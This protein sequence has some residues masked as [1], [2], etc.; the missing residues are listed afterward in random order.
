MSEPVFMQMML[1]SSTRIALIYAYRIRSFLVL[2]TTVSITSPPHLIIRGT[3]QWEFKSNSTASQLPVD[4]RVGIESVVHTTTLLLIQNDLQDLAAI[5]LGSESLAHDLNGVDNVGENSVVDGS[6]G[7]AARTLLSLR[8]AGA[9]AAFG[10]G[11]NT[12]G[13]ED[14]DMAVGELLLELSGQALLDLVEAWQKRNWDK[15]DNSALA[16][17]N[18]ELFIK[19]TLVF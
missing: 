7:S 18:F 17:A 11:E 10:A 14:Q 3:A 2:I 15:D 16:V 8:C 1:V 4:L 9:V 12:A 13:C 5:F 6:Q 19:T